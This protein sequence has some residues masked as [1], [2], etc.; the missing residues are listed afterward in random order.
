MASTKR[1]FVPSRIA[2]LSPTTT[3]TSTGTS[4]NTQVRS[5]RSYYFKVTFSFSNKFSVKFFF[6]VRN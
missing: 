1:R 4:G 2:P 5:A 3:R 6:Y